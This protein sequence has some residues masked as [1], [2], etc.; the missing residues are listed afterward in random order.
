[1]GN[2]KVPEVYWD[3]PAGA[4]IPSVTQYALLPHLGRLDVEFRSDNHDEGHPA[5]ENVLTLV[6]RHIRCPNVTTVLAAAANRRIKDLQALQACILAS[7]NPS[8]VQSLTLTEMADE[9]LAGLII[10]LIEKLPGLKSIGLEFKT[11]DK[12]RI[13]ALRWLNDPS[14]ADEPG[15]LW[16]NDIDRLKLCPLL[17]SLTLTHCKMNF[18]CFSLMISSR[19]GP[20]KSPSVQQLTSASMEE[21]ELSSHCG[22]PPSTAEKHAAN[23]VKVQGDALKVES[24][25][26]I[27]ATSREEEVHEGVG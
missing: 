12:V 26:D 15:R 24:A 22:C 11:Y 7:G 16:R 13:D 17:S 10:E 6:L 23:L 25:V 21:T 4:P 9:S 20:L 1:M 14:E 27:D 5:H 18:D 3:D 2:I 19:L 8:S